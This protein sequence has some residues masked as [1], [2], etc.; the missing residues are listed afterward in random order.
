MVQQLSQKRTSVLYPYSCQDS[1]EQFHALQRSN[2][3]RKRLI[4]KCEGEFPSALGL[5]VWSCSSL[6][7]FDSQVPTIILNRS[8]DTKY[9]VCL[10]VLGHRFIKK[11][12]RE[13]ESVCP[14]SSARKKK[15]AVHW[16]ASSVA[17]ASS[18]MQTTCY[19]DFHFTDEHTALLCHQK[20]LR[21]FPKFYIYIYIYYYNNIS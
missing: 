18:E 19:Q 9:S 16:A 6:L 12:S 17:S 4:P 13:S 21:F 5:V 15:I 8:R 3:K 20:D 14:Q 2:S 7:S 11:H 1:L 10:F